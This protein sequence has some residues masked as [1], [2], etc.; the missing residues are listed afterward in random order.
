MVERESVLVIGVD[1]ATDPRK[2]GLAAGIW[3]GQT[4]EI[5]EMD[6][7]GWERSPAS[8]IAEQALRL[9]QCACLLA[10]DAPLGW[11]AGFGASL[12]G[13]SAG[14]EIEAEP[15]DFFRR[16]TD[17]FIARTVGRRPLD[18]GAE[19]IARTALAA[20]RLVAQVSRRLGTEIPLVWGPEIPCGLGAVEVYPAALLQ[21]LGL[22]ASR[23]K[24]SGQADARE[25]ILEGLKPH[26]GLPGDTSRAL[27]DADVLDALV[28][29]MA[30]VDFLA[31]RAMPPGDLEM[32]KKEGWI[33]VRQP[34]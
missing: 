27:E 17:R 14:Q 5:R 16:E 18:V 4:C 34:T 32:A 9:R 28:C 25:E 11:P 30:G 12:A 22:P 20:L 2:V 3:D 10:L 26:L 23:Y 29:V 21:T 8:W 15:A 31:G 1:C 6:A 13:H 19:R 33:W 7:A 24:E